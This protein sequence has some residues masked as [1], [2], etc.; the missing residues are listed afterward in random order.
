M[1]TA[2][3]HSQYEGLNERYTPGVA[4]DEDGLIGPL[5]PPARHGGRR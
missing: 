3:A 4:D 5:L 2:F 1:W